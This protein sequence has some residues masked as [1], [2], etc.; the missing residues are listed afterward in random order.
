[1]AEGLFRA[2]KADRVLASADVD[3]RR[4]YELRASR[5]EP[6]LDSGEEQPQITQG[7]GT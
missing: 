2:I 6:G 3:S 5:S 7:P 4:Q 1:V